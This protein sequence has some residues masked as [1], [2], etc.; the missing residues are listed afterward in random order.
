MIL[1]SLLLAGVA[2]SYELAQDVIGEGTCSLDK[3]EVT[4][5]GMCECNKECCNGEDSEKMLGGCPVDVVVAIDM[6]LCTNTTMSAYKR[7]GMEL[8]NSL[9]TEFGISDSENSARLHI[10]QFM[11]DTHDVTTFNTFTK[12]ELISDVLRMDYHQYHGKATN[13][14]KAVQY[15]AKILQTSE[16]VN[17]EPRQIFVMITN[18]YSDEDLVSQRDVEAE[19]QGLQGVPNLR[20]VFVARGDSSIAGDQNTHTNEDVAKYFDQRESLGSFLAPQQIVNDISCPAPPPMKLE[21]ECKCTCDVPMGCH[22]PQGQPGNDGRVGKPGKKGPSGERG[23]PG[24]DGPMGEVGEQ[25]EPGGCGMPGHAGEKGYPGEDGISG[26]NGVRGRQGERGPPG[27][28]GKAGPKG[29]KGDTGAP[30]AP[31]ADGVIGEPG[32]PGQAGEPGPQGGLDQKTLKWLVNKIF[33]EELSAMG[34]N[35]PQT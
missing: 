7:F 22:G 19:L 27:L 18:G 35:T 23:V 33:M 30:G 24:E 9:N 12:G 16:R 26:I 14:R 11:E 34:I 8:I 10:F 15:G 17:A 21:R 28:P 1:R 4:H 5:L 25:G 31:G 29:E 13:V 32:D 6:C 3:Q 20:T 2:L